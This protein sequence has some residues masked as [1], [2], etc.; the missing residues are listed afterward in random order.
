LYSS[1]TAILA[2]PVGIGVS[3]PN[4]TLHVAGGNAGQIY[5]TNTVA[6]ATYNM[7]VASNSGFYI[8]TNPGGLGVFLSNGGTSWNAFAS[9]ARLKTNVATISSALS[10]ITQLRPVTFT[11]ITDKEGVVPRSG[12]IAQEV[13]AVFP[14]E[15]TWVTTVN[16]GLTC[17]DATGECFYP[18][19]ISQTEL[20]PYLVRS[21]QELS[22]ENGALQARVSM[23]E[24]KVALLE[25]QLALILQRLAAAGIQ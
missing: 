14:K 2:G 10:R 11:Y 5:M 20:I 21:V 17:L 8:Y 7:G 19:T 22:E 18:L 6:N 16:D 12:F 4:N 9:D 24:P 23:L 13:D 15:S 25:T 1:G 3:S